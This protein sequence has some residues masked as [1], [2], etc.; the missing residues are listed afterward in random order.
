MNRAAL[1]FV[2]I[3]CSKPLPGPAP[4]PTVAKPLPSA[5]TEIAKSAAPMRTPTGEIEITA[6]ELGAASWVDPKSLTECRTEPMIG[7]VLLR[8]EV[9][10]DGKATKSEVLERVGIPE[11]TAKCIPAKLQFPP[12]AMGFAS[13]TVYVAFR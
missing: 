9:A 7:W 6:F 1:M 3:G 5:E 2:L 13:L 8:L 11:K 12:P 4:N 10:A